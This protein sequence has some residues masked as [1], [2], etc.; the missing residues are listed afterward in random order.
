MVKNDPNLIAPCGMNCGI[1]KAYLAYT[2]NIPKQKGKITHCPGCRIR[3]KQC[4]FI[5]GRC[6]KLQSGQVNSC[7][8]CKDMPC[9]EISKIDNRYRERYHYSFITNLKKIKE[10]GPKKVM[11]DDA[12]RFKCPVCGGT[13]S[14][15][16]GQCYD[17]LAKKIHQTSN[18]K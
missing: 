14:I 18:S 3:N 16:D 8:E 6:A 13:I 4:A 9:Y 2:H 1:C 7:S 15:H 12:E 17:C 10:F 11:A 5:K